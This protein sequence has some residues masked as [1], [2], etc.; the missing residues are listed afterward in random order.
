[1]LMTDSRTHG[2]A[3]RA[4]RL[5]KKK[6]SRASGASRAPARGRGARRR[7]VR[8]LGALEGAA[9]QTWGYHR[10]PEAMSGAQPC[11]PHVV[12]WRAQALRGLDRLEATVLHV[13]PCQT[14][15]RRR[16]NPRNPRNRKRFRVS[17]NV[18]ARDGENV[19]AAR[20]LAA[21][22]EWVAAESV[23]AYARVVPSRAW[24]DRYVWDAR[25]IAATVQVLDARLFRY[26]RTSRGV[27][28][29]GDENF[30]QKFSAK[31]RVANPPRARSTP[32]RA[33]LL[34][35]AAS[36]TLASLPRLRS[37]GFDR[38]EI[39]ES[40]R[41]GPVRAPLVR[42][43]RRARGRRRGRR[44]AFGPGD[45]RFAWRWT[46]SRRVA[47]ETDRTEFGDDPRDDDDLRD[48]RVRPDLREHCSSTPFSVPAEL[49]GAEPK[50]END[51][52]PCAKTRRASLA[53][54]DDAWAA[55][56][57]R[58]AASPAN[59]DARLAA[60]WHRSE[61]ST[62]DITPLD[63]E[64]AAMKQALVAEC[65][66]VAEV[67]SPCSATTPVVR[68]TRR[69]FRGTV[70]STDCAHPLAP[71][72][73]ALFLRPSS[74]VTRSARTMRGDDRRDDR[75]DRDRSRDHRDHGVGRGWDR[76]ADYRRRDDRD[77]RRHRDRDRSRS[78][79]RSPGRYGRDHRDGRDGHHDPGR[80]DDRRHEHPSAP[81]AEPAPAKRAEVR[82]VPPTRVSR[83]SE[84][85][86]IHRAQLLTRRVRSRTRR[87]RRR[88]PLPSTSSL[89][90]VFSP[91]VP[92]GWG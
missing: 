1:M 47:E 38:R 86:S 7:G 74:A 35:C 80:H 82:R 32:E 66:D 92:L 83:A 75:R 91:R 33:A 44:R 90:P 51:P 53:R 84:H 72:E 41:H 13:F 68:N 71:R 21:Y 48:A 56:E 42:S 46:P 81:A 85:P 70:T 28:G 25:T 62:S 29:F 58:L 45:A 14:T 8:L 43:R 31:R 15:P 54:I 87:P 77:D 61:L 67:R 88:D 37:P 40:S 49:V 2:L 39:D 18:F 27:A 65:R 4:E 69:Y 19:F 78:R 22:A 34:R 10:K 9:A 16:R 20:S 79:S 3:E 26:E 52:W 5:S 24:R 17:R 36:E 73:T 64:E 76:G 63:P 59:D 89:S 55:A 6:R 11:S 50:P 30:F 12:V 60:L 23:G 57:A